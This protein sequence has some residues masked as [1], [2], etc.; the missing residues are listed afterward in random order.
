MRHTVAIVGRPN[1]GKSTLFNKLVGDRLSIVKDEPGVTRDRLYRE[2]EW[3]GQKF[4]LVDTGG[5]EPRTED[6]MMSKIKKQAQV[7]IDEADVIIFLVDG[8]AGITGL[9]EDVATVLRKQGKKV[10]V[11]VNKIDNYIKEKENIFEFYGLGFE[12]VIGISGEHKTNLGDLLDAVIEKFE[13]KNVKEI[14][15]GLSIAILG[16]PNAGKSSLLNKLLNKERSI[17]SDIAGTTR[18]TID[19]A[20]KYNGDMYTLIDTA[21]I[22]RKSKVEDDIEYYSVLRAMK[23]IKRADVCVLMLDATEL[24][25]DQDKRI[26]GMIYDERKPII[27]TINKWDLIEKNDNSVKEFTEL[28]KA[29]LAFLDYAPIITISALTGKRT[30]NILEQAKFINEEYHK[31]VTTGILNQILAEIVAQNPVPTRKGRA[32]KINYATQISQA[33]PKFVFFTNNP[34]LIHFSY[35]R[36]IENKLREYFGFEGCPIEIVFNKKADKTF[37]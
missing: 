8:K 29:D 18:D 6:F 5:L 33:P 14:S 1:V 30:L 26:A 21:G 3:L 37:G 2:M 19:S 17:V 20:L 16:R 15:E 36:Y 9:D 12:E 34:E 31:K 7:A 32:V 13:D 28:V 24:L 35:K 4:I 27:I 23:A 25:T 11:A 10:I 22:R